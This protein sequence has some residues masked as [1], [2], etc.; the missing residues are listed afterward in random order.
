MSV[1]MMVGL[2]VVFLMTIVGIVYIVNEV[3]YPD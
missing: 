2:G 3:M 1:L